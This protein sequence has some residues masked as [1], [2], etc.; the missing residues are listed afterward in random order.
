MRVAAGVADLARRMIMMSMIM[1]TVV[2]GM[3]M[4]RMVVMVMRVKR[5]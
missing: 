5:M 1:R 3:I 4:C 2:V